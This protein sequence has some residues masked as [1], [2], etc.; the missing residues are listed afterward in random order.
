MVTVFYRPHKHRHDRHT[1]SRSITCSEKVFLFCI[2]HIMERLV[3]AVTFDTTFPD[4]RIAL[5]RLILK[6]VLGSIIGIRFRINNDRVILVIAERDL[7]ALVTSGIAVLHKEKI[8]QLSCINIQ[9]QRKSIRLD[10]KLQLFD[11]LGRRTLPSRIVRIYEIAAR[12]KYGFRR[13]RVFGRFLSAQFPAQCFF[14]VERFFV[15][16]S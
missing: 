8:I 12:F 1:S 2:G 5:N 6:L 16:S 3:S 11:Q 9:F 4:I 7:S 10:V 14:V 15:T 13:L